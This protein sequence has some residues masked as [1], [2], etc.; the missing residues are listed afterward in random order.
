MIL[1]HEAGV[2]EAP[3]LASA[4]MDSICHS[5]SFERDYDVNM[6]IMYCLSFEALFCQMRHNGELID[7]ID[8]PTLE[9]SV[10][11]MI[12][13][14]SKIMRMNDER[15]HCLRWVKTSQSCVK[16]FAML[17]ENCLKI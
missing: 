12:D 16:V 14:K 6:H 9:K 1:A 11:G 2:P 10:V 7:R 5:K 15:M 3:Q 4:I 17:V 13:R 8:V